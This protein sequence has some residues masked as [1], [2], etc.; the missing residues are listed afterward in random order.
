MGSYIANTNES[1]ALAR[2]IP[3]TSQRQAVLLFP[4][5]NI[6][7]TKEGNDQAQRVQRP[8]I[9]IL[10]IVIPVV[11]R[12]WCI[13]MQQQRTP[14]VDSHDVVSAVQTPCMQSIAQSSTRQ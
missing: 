1:S 3:T 8:W 7:P 2:E 12:R 11:G 9:L 13:L 10:I 14:L 4:P 6:L 5:A